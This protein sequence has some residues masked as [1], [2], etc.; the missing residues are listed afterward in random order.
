[1]AEEE[2]PSP[3]PE[4]P[5]EEEEVLERVGKGRSASLAREIDE[6]YQQV[7][8][9]LSSVALQR[10]AERALQRLRLARDILIED[11]RQFDEAEYQVNQVRLLLRRTAQSREGARRYSL[12]IFGYEVGWFIL[13]VAG[14]ILRT[15]LANALT[16]ITG[17][18]VAE[19]QANIVPLL[20]TMM[21][22]GVGGVIGALYSLHWHVSEQQDY[23]PQFNLSYL[24]KPFMGLVLG[25]II[26]L[27]VRTGFLALQATGS[28]TARAAEWFPFLVACLAGFR[29]TFAYEILDQLIQVITP[30]PRREEEEE[31]EIAAQAPASSQG[32]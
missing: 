8:A 13:F 12:C 24:V 26:Y 17:Q 32:R 20:V 16:Y 10:K 18:S 22:G 4:E 28:T 31:E 6:L 11:P 29:Q 19:L 25:G 9:E 2:I 1:M 15:P 7:G 5:S 3:P 30:T 14:I 23:D 27:V 21:W